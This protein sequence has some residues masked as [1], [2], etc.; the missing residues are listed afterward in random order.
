MRILLVHLSDIHLTSSTDHIVLKMDTIASA[1]QNLDYELD[2]CIVAVT[3]DVAYSGSAEQYEIAFTMFATLIK[4]LEARLT[5]RVKGIA[6]PIKFVAVPGNHDCSFASTTSVR[7]H[8]LLAARADPTD[9]SI[10]KVCLEPQTAFFE[11][12]EAI[13]DFEVA[14]A[15]STNFDKRIS[16][17]LEMIV[18]AERLVFICM[19]SAWLSQLKE[20]Q[21]SLCFPVDALPQNRPN[22]ALVI[23]MMHHPYNWLEA[24]EARRV[25]KRLESISDL[26]ITGHEHDAQRRIQRGDKGEYF[27]HVEGG[28]LQDSSDSSAS[29]FNAFVIDTVEKKQK[30]ISYSW[31]N[32]MYL[33]N[34]TVLGE[35]G[36]G[37]TW[38]ELPINRARQR[39]L[40]EPCKSVAQFL[41]D[42]GIIL[43]HRKGDLSLSDIFVMPNLHEQVFLQNTA[44]RFVKGNNVVQ[45]A[46]KEPRL[47]ITGDSQSGRTSLGKVLFTKLLSARMVP[48]WLNYTDTPS[49]IA[50]DRIFGYLENLFVKQY[51]VEAREA[52]QQLDRERRVIIIDDY[53]RLAITSGKKRKFLEKISR[54]SGHVILLAHDLAQGIDEITHP[55]GHLPFARFR[56]QQLAHGLRGQLVDQWFSMHSEADQEDLGLAHR[57]IEVHRAL[58]TI[59]GKNFVPAY[60][61]YIL[62]ILQASE[63]GTQLNLNASTHG[64]FYEL[65]I[66]ST[67]LKNRS[68]KDYD[69]VMSYLGFIA[70]CVFSN[71]KVGNRDFSTSELRKYHEE[72]ERKY[73]LSRSFDQ[74]LTQLT[75]CGVFLANSD[76]YRFRYD[77]IYYF[78]IACY[79]RDHIHVDSVKGQITTLSKKLYKSESANILLFLAHLSRDPFIIEQLIKAADEHYPDLAP[80]QLKSDVDFINQL[81]ERVESIIYDEVPIQK[82]RQDYLDTLDQKDRAEQLIDDNIDALDDASAVVDPIAGLNAALKTMQILGQILKNFFG[83]L[84]GEPKYNIADRC[85]SL[86]LRA[87]SF[88]FE[89]IRTNEEALLKD[90]VLLL[91][92]RYPD[93][94]AEDAVRKARWAIVA[95]SRLVSFGIIKRISLA[96]GS[97]DLVKTY[98]KVLTANPVPSIKVVHAALALEHTGVFP[99]KMICDL[100][101]EFKSNHLVHW[102]LQGFVLEY[103]QLFPVSISIK[104]RICAKLSIKYR[105]VNFLNEATSQLFDAGKT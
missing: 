19:N 16:F 27:S 91:R 37:L 46:M 97:Q 70:F 34:T 4:M 52:Y 15:S 33:S 101:E 84:E 43:K 57:I 12:L 81:Q 36:S 51:Q 90:I 100:A 25:R 5:S 72:Y 58:D 13:S 7:P 66:K 28:Q 92:E 14:K 44:G 86:G 38:E 9:S 30:S 8:L 62:S 56:I 96:V 61:V 31:Q 53:D 23:A 10:Q 2:L 102:L 80:A 6:V 40:F 71:G 64:Y 76:C 41:N 98:E 89:L 78:F 17:E 3:G 60:P 103:F 11:F 50:D 87:L 24:T 20:E 26:V 47:I 99:D 21:G 79:L 69:F 105:P 74:M 95:L 59:I 63:T 65:F 68:Q 77:Y 94:T 35:E 67:L 83:S 75:D 22:A 55:S 18:N 29:H 54:F 45:L 39:L 48:I 1:V 32:D 73:D 93:S 82:S 104:H 42:P 88:I 49:S 85:Y